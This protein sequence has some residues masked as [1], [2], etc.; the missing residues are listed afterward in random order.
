MD[1]DN[2]TKSMHEKTPLNALYSYVYVNYE[3]GTL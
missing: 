1:N 3:N 2:S